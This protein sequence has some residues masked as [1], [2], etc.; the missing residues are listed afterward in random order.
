VNEE[1][2]EIRANY[3]A[4][5]HSIFSLSKLRGYLKKGLMFDSVY[6]QYDDEPDLEIKISRRVADRIQEGSNNIWKYSV[7]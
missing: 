2:L 5:F 6:L 3:A 7:E 4:K 1:E